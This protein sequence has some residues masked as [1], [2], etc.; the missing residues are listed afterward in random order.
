VPEIY[1]FSGNEQ[2][3]LDLNLTIQENN[4]IHVLFS[5]SSLSLLVLDFRYLDYRKRDNKNHTPTPKADLN[6]CFMRV[7]CT[8]N[9]VQDN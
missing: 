8:L 4:A 5:S 2:Y 6:T 1:V 3:L 9:R 7:S